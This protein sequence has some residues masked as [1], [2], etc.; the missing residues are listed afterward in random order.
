MSKEYTI[1]VVE[2]HPD[3]PLPDANIWE[4]YTLTFDATACAHE[5]LSWQVD[6]GA[7][8]PGITLDEE[9]GELSGTPTLTGD[10]SFT[11]LLQTEAS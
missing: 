3:S 2:I 6:S 11:I 7:L 4:D 10:Y 8:P 9:T 1:C 5:P